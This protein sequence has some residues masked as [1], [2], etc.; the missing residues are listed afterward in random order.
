[1]LLAYPNYAIIALILI[2]TEKQEYMPSWYRYSSIVNELYEK[3]MN[4]T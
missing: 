4:D 1:M 3:K 2:L